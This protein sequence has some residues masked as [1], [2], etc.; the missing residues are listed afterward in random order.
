MTPP[1]KGSLP[2]PDTSGTTMAR[3]FTIGPNPLAAAPTPAHTPPIGEVR[4]AHT[5]PTGRSGT[6]PDADGMKRVSYYITTE[7]ADA[8]DAAVV[9]IL[10]VL[11]P[12]TP[13]HVALSA[14]IGAGAAAAGQITV[15]LAQQRAEDLA[16]RAAA[17]RSRT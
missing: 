8:L 13:R 7:T 11:G 10:D 9:E 6:R 17:L 14:V 16:A 2:P 4:A 3:R 1:K 5:R 15:D 12:D